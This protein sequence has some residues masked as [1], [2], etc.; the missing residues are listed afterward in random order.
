MKKVLHGAAAKNVISKLLRSNL[1]T[2]TV[3]DVVLT[4]PDAYSAIVSK[5]I[6]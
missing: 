6:S 3:T 5:S 1:V 2:A 4:I